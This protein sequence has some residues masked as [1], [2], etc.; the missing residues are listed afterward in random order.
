MALVVNLP[1]HKL[2]VVVYGGGGGRPLDNAELR[3]GLAV[4]RIID[5]AFTAT[6]TATETGTW[7]TLSS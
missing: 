4:Q 6:A 5:A 3:D 1:R 2:A 7:V